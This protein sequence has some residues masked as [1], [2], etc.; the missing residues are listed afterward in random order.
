MNVIRRGT[1]RRHHVRSCAGPGKSIHAVAGAE[2]V[3]FQSRIRQLFQR[4]L[5]SAQPS[6]RISGQTLAAI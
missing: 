1:K 5:D 4:T 3:Y 2:D 6:R